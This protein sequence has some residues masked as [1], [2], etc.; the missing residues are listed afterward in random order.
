[1]TS[2]WW[3]DRSCAYQAW[4]WPQCG[5]WTEAETGAWNW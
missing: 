1:M 3:S 2:A 4:P 5:H